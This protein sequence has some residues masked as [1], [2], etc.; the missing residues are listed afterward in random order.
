MRKILIFILCI[1]LMMCAVTVFASATSEIP[2]EAE[3]VVTKIEEKNSASEDI[4]ITESIVEQVK[5][6]FPEIAIL[7]VSLALSI[8]ISR[9]KTKLT[10]SMGVMN[11]N[12]INIAKSSDAATKAN[13]EKMEYMTTKFEEG[14]QMMSSLLEEIRKNAEEKKSLEDTL[15]SVES[16]LAVSKM[17]TLEMSNEVADLLLLS[18][19]PNSKKEEL[20]AR[21]TK[22]VHELEAVEEVKSDEVEES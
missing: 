12:A 16:F 9:L 10:T 7:L 3:S 20:Y 11:N 1:T 13:L 14:I 8:F 21:H 19:I 5:E 17:A 22:A 4:T 18:N 2:A 6:K 15:N